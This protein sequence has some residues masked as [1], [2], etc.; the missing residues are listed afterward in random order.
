RQLYS[1][2]IGKVFSK[3][4]LGEFNKGEQFPNMIEYTLDGSIQGVMLPTLSAHNGNPEKIKSILRKTVTSSSY[5]IIACM[6]GMAA[7]SK[8]LVLVLLTDKWLGCV[9]FL[10]LS[11]LFYC[12]YPI[13]FSNQTAINAMGRS[14]IYLKL[15]IIKKVIGIVILFAS[16]PFGLIP[17]AWGRVIAGFISVVITVIPNRRLLDYRFREVISDV[18]PSFLCGVLMFCVVYFIQFVIPLNPLWVLLIQVLVGVVVYLCVSV[19]FR[20]KALGYVWDEMKQKF[21]KKRG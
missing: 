2:V 17:M 18:A 20:V 19:L 6:F 1:L 16:I 15:E 21:G 10:M 9:P 5:L 14:D 4:E 12:L 3:S 11:C 13:Q 7:V 8:N